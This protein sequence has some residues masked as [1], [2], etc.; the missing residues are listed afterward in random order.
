MNK[1]ND[2]IEK[3]LQKIKNLYYKLDEIMDS[4]PEGVPESIKEPIKKAI[5]GDKELRELMEG[6]DKFRAPRFMMVGRTGVGKS[7]LVN[8]I[9]GKYL[10]EVSDVEIGTTGTKSF[11]Y[12]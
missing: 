11:E 4:L 2:N 9:C 10:A 6:L 7:S 3:R 5:F 8:A 1:E 12:I